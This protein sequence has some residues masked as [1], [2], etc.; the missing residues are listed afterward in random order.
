MD[1]DVAT[2]SPED[3]A[4]T[5]GTSPWWVREQARRGRIPHLRLGRQRIRF[6]PEQVNALVRLSTVEPAKDVAVTPAPIRPPT[7]EAL[8]ATQR[9]LKAHRSPT[10]SPS[11]GNCSPTELYRSA[12]VRG[13]PDPS[14]RQ[15]ESVKAEHG[16]RR[17]SDRQTS[18]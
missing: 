16:R 3:V 2:L 9:S 18:K 12:D 5:L 4:R 8:G 14:R 17:S 6:L 10:R 15:A 11:L 13:K 1:G 7:L